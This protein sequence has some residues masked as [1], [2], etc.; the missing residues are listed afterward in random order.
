MVDKADDIDIEITDDA[1]DADAQPASEK[2]ALEPE[3]ALE[4]LR[5]QLAAANARA[6]AATRRLSE[7]TLKSHSAQS[8]VHDTNLHLISTAI[9]SAKQ[10]AQVLKAQ[11]SAAMSAG[12][13]DAA[14]ELQEAI[15]TN[16]AKLLQ[17]NQGKEAMEAA[18]KPA[19]PSA[20]QGDPVEQMAAQL[21]PRSAQWVRAHPQFATDQ[22]LFQRMLAAHNLAVTDGLAA[23]TDEYFDAVETTLGLRRAQARADADLDP[24]ADAAQITQRRGAAPPA[25]PVSRSGNGTGGQRRSVRLTQAEIEAAEASGQTPEEYARN[26]LELQKAGRL[27]LN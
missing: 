3:D 23:D 24:L 26:K 19:A 20:I 21:S 7:E 2:R 15:S 5:A 4:A 25:A 1:P 9:E 11:Y 6:D 27:S 10:N 16:A 22:R 13:Y 12:D 18:P 17:L 8:E 14:A